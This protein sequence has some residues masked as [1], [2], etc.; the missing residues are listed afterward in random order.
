[1]LSGLRVNASDLTYIILRVLMACAVC[2]TQSV[3]GLEH[4]RP[5][6][7]DVWTQQPPESVDFSNK[8]NTSLHIPSA[9]NIYQWQCAC[10]Y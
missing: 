10:I 6:C 7:V 3:L 5:W 2:F 9:L 8:N 1:M 4:L